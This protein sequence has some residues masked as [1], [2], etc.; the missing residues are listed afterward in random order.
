[1]YGIMVTKGNVSH[2]MLT[3]SDCGDYF[4]PQ[5]MKSLELAEKRIEKLL[6]KNPD[7]ITY[8]AVEITSSDIENIKYPL[9]EEV[10]KR[11][12]QKNKKS[13]KKSKDGIEYFIVDF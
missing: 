11:D 3:I 5:E 8:S 13:S 9:D 4:V 2:L 1:M 7:K 6:L 10:E 12:K